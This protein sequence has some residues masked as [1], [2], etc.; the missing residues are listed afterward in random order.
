MTRLIWNAVGERFFE[1]GVDHGIIFVGDSSGVP[2]NGLLSVNESHSGGDVSSYYVDGVKYLA[3]AS[4]EEYEATVEAYTYPD[5][6]GVCVGDTP[7]KNGLFVTKQP[8]KPFHFCYRTRVGNDVDGVEHGFKL[9]LVYNALAESSDITS[10]SIKDSIDP[11][12]FSWKLTTKP[13]LFGGYKPTP[14]FV[15][16]SRETPSAIMV[17]ILDILYGNDETDSRM[18]SVDELIY[19]FSEYE[20][21]A[22]DAGEITDPDPTLAE[23]DRG[24][25]PGELISSTIDGGTP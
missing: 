14:H 7:V 16:D 2:W 8:K 6:F 22:F 24:D 3:K 20:A 10:S 15:I 19:I 11:Y 9:H 4:N 23:F 17:E 21:T 1:A 13:P 25:T 18:P 12:N 5:E